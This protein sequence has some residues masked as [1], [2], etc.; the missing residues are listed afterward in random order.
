MISDFF[1][2][3]FFSFNISWSIES[4]DFDVSIEFIDSSELTVSSSVY[5]LLFFV[6]LIFLF[7]LLVDFFVFGELCLSCSILFILFDDFNF[8][9]F[10]LLDFDLLDFDLLDFDLFDFVVLFSKDFIF[11][12]KLFVV[13]GSFIFCKLV[14]EIALL[15]LLVKKKKFSLNLLGFCPI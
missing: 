8:S 11:F 1:L 2:S 3:C 12:S 15:L 5:F 6:L 10:D 13:F 4:I 9:D 7:L 14:P